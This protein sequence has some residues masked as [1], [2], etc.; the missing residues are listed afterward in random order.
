MA[1]KALEEAG[2]HFVTQPTFADKNFQPDIL[3]DYEGK[4]FAIELK[5]SPI[6]YA[7]ILDVCDLPVTKSFIISS[8][9]LGESTTANVRKYADIRSVKLL[10]C[11]DFDS[12]VNDIF[13]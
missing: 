7:D 4:T 8:C 12:L 9:D 6:G 1:M 5:S 11:D 10:D 13:A 3:A 2:V